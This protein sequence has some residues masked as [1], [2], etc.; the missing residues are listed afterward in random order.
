MYVP[1]VTENPNFKRRVKEHDVWHQKKK[2]KKSEISNDGKGFGGNS[3]VLQSNCEG[4]LTT[5]NIC[6]LLTDLMFAGTS[7]LCQR[8][9]LVNHFL[10]VVQSWIQSQ[11][12]NNFN[13]SALVFSPR[14]RAEGRRYPEG[15]RGSH[16]LPLARRCPL[17]ICSLPACQCKNPPGTGTGTF[18]RSSGLIS[19]K[20]GEDIF[21]W[22]LQ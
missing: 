4:D 19:W 15:W 6:S 14:S 3:I 2:K 9:F 1:L 20:S 17:R 5:T 21:L 11:Y 8:V 22:V 10:C 7:N 13:T 12:G 18:I 16:G